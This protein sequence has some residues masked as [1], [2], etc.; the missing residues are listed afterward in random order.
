VHI[1][2]SVAGPGTLT[3][4]TVRVPASNAA[5]PFD[6]ART[7]SA[8]VGATVSVWARVDGARFMTWTPEGA[9]LVSQPSLGVVTA[10]TPSTA[11]QSP[12]ASRVLSGL[13]AP[14]GM[15]F[16][17]LDGRRVLYVAESD[18]LDRYDWVGS[19]PVDRQVVV[20]DLPDGNTRPGG[21]NHP[22]KDVVI[23][24]DHTIYLDVA[25]A[26]NADPADR[27]AGEA[28]I[29]SYRS[30]GTGRRVLMTGVRNGDGLAL[31]PAGQL[32]TAVNNRDRI[33]VPRHVAVGSVPDAYGR[34]L[35]SYVNDHPADEIAKVIAGRDL[36]WP[37][38]NPDQD[39]ASSSQ[40]DPFGQMRF[41][42]DT[43]SN[44]NG[45]HFDCAALPPLER[46]IAA[47]SAP[48]GLD[49]LGAST[50]PARWRSAAVVATHG[51]NGHLPPLAGSVLWLP[52]SLAHGG[53][54]GAARE[55]LAGFATGTDRWGRPVDAL[56][57][58]DG[59]LY[60]SDDTAGAVYRITLPA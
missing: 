46:G 20:R 51:S 40:V 27:A 56:P 42:P 48:L 7:L 26:S 4:L 36:G 41:A 32:W 55:L 21:Y 31:D 59:A 30:D 18:Q 25:S 45:Q 28:L 12:T 37:Y 24:P 58:P 38:C 49:F 52:W 15:A 54:L 44:A 3:P 13:T 14:Q 43:E 53:T 16:D 39:L 50:L 19:R 1:A 34:V 47:H 9:L 11:T 2:P 33:S 23:G 17:T 60:V 57:G 29:A 6:V 5:P 35:Q 22:L 10:L 8:P